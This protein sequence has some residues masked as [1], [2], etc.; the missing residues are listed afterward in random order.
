MMTAFSVR[1]E[2]K[3][4]RWQSHPDAFCIDSALHSVRCAPSEARAG[5]LGVLL[6]FDL[7]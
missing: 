3:T 6:F 5:D 7:R 2:S 1:F 4:I